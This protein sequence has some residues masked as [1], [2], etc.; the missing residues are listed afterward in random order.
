MSE[1]PKQTGRP[2]GYQKAVDWIAGERH[3][4]FT[5]DK[6]QGLVAFLWGKPQ[7][8]VA[9]D[10]DRAQITLRKGARP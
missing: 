1:N 9:Q 5:C 4:G 6:S 10:V 3:K 8:R 2:K 7:D